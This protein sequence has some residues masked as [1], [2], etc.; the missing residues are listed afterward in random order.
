M[1]TFKALSALLSYPSHE[2]QQA[3][4]AIQAV[5]AVDV[6]VGQ[7]CEPSIRHRYRS[8]GRRPVCLA[9]LASMRGPI[10]SPS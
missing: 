5:F 7:G 6:G 3:V 1:K 8:S 10:S 9:T 2:L 4:T